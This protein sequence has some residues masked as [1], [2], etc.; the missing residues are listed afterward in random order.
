LGAAKY[1][2]RGEFVAKLAVVWVGLLVWIGFFQ[3]LG[4]M[5]LLDET[6]PM[7]VEA[8]RQM[9][10]SGDW[11]TPMFN[12]APRFDKPPLVYWLMTI[13]FQTIGPAA[14]VAKLASALPATLIVVMLFALLRW[15]QRQTATLRPVIPYLGAAIAAL[16]LQMWFFGRMGYSDMLLNLG[17]SGGLISFFVAYSQPEKPKAQRGWYLVMFLALGL[18]LLTKGPIAVVLPGLIIGIFLRLSRQWRVIWHEIPWGWG[19]LLTGAIAVPWY[20]QIIQLHGTAFTDAFFGFHNVQRF[21]RV[22]NQHSGPWYYHWLI[23]LPGLL[24]WS[25]A[26]PS[27]IGQTFRRPFHNA[28]RIEQLG[29]FG[30][31]WFAVVMGFFTIASTKYVT[32]SLPAVPAAAIVIALWW[33]DAI[34]RQTWGL[35]LTNY[36]TLASFAMLGIATWYAPNWLNDDPSMPG[37][38]TAFGRSGLP[39]IG[40]GIWAIGLLLGI[41]YVHQSAFWRVKVI[42]AAAFI[43]LFVTPSFAVVDQVRQLPLRQVAAVIR[44]E[45]RP[46]EPIAMA[47]GSFGKPSVLF[48][49]Q[50]NLALM[51]DAAEVDPYLRSLAE[52]SPPPATLLLITTAVVRQ[53]ASFPTVPAEVI[54][55]IGIYQLLR[56]S[57][58]PPENSPNAAPTS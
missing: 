40:A 37:L 6:E 49:S 14:W 42:T 16:N 5:E 47:T 43:L 3:G 38:G 50:Q 18:G 32:Y 24:P 35:R 45:H 48:Y 44:A 23:L 20:W 58:G 29:Q 39:T 2:D 54:T 12:G 9:A 34:R 27:A 31:I 11:L 57:I 8:A 53:A 17:I 30:L 28:P 13:G 36:G 26:L 15:V 19:L 25:V 4:A 21:T 10:L 41:L 22:V 51:R 55:E 33:N 46:E 56:L 1:G 52:R 7:F